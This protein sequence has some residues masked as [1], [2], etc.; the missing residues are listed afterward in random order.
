MLRPVSPAPDISGIL[1]SM[2]QRF[3]RWMIVVLLALTGALGLYDGIHEW[4]AARSP[5]QRTVTIC[6]LLYGLFGI[7]AAV[8]M[9]RR[10]RWAVWAAAGWA[11]ALT[12]AGGLAA[13]AY[14][15]EATAGGA[16]VA[17]I[18]SALIGVFAVWIAYRTTR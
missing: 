6:I 7:L 16:L 8:G 9:I 15:P 2:I 12:Y 10:S 5:L 4:H 11:L 18:A 1:H 17:G 13:I 14:A 3:A